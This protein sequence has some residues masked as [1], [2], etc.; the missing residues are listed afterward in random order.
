MG[1]PSWRLT[2]D[3]DITV[4]VVTSDGKRREMDGFAQSGDLLMVNLHDTE[5]LDIM[6]HTDWIILAWDNT[7]MAEV[8]FVN[9]N[10][11]V[12]AVRDTCS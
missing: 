7:I 1:N 4:L 8:V 3:A 5:M 12:Q 11:G 9:L 6:Q 2:P 10:D